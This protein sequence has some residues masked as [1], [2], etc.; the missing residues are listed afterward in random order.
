MIIFGFHEDI[1]GYF[2][3]GVLGDQFE[4]NK[5]ASHGVGYWNWNDNMVWDQIKQELILCLVGEGKT[6]E[7][8]WI[9]VSGITTSETDSPKDMMYEWLAQ[10][11]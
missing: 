1:Y 11:N 3:I 7:G 5:Y 2:G 6:V 9:E 4:E 8:C 10:S